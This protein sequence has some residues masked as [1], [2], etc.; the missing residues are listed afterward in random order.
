MSADRDTAQSRES[1]NATAKA[2]QRTVNTVNGN[3]AYTFDDAKRR[4][5]DA[6]RNG[7]MKRDNRNR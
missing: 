5:T 4:V 1:I 2:W 3:D 6:R 7:D